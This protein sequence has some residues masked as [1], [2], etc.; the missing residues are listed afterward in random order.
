[1]KENSAHIFIPCEG[2]SS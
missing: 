1:M 2:R